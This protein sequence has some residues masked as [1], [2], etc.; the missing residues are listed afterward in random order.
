VFGP[1]EAAGWL[2]S[3]GKVYVSADNAEV[4]F[5]VVKLPG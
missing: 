3:D 2:Q 4:Y 5:G 1:F